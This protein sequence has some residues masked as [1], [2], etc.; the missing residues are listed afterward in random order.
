MGEVKVE[1]PTIGRSALGFIT[2]PADTRLYL[3]GYNS[4]EVD[5]G[6]VSWNDPDLQDGRVMRIATSNRL[7][8]D[9]ECVSLPFLVSGAVMFRP[10]SQDPMSATQGLRK[11]LVHK[12]PAIDRALFRE[13]KKFFKIRM[14]NHYRPIRP[15]EV[16]TYKEW[17]DGVNHPEWRKLEYDKAY[18]DVVNGRVDL[19]N[20]NKKKCFVKREFYPEPK[21]HRAIHSPTDHE[22][23]IEGP[24]A[25]AIENQV[26]SRPEYI[27]TV[28]RA[29]WPTYIRD[30]VAF[31]NLRWFSSDYSSFEASFVPEIQ[32]STE[33]KMAKFIL[34]I[35]LHLR[36]PRQ[37][38]SDAEVKIL[39][40]TLFYA[41]IR[42]RRSSGKMTTSVFNGV[43]NPAFVEFILRFL[44]GATEVYYVVE[45]DDGLYGHNGL[46]DPTPGDFLRLGLQIKLIPVDN[47]Y[48]ASFC[49]VVTHPDV[50]HTLCDPW[51][52]LLTCSWAG[53]D[54]VRAKPHVLRNLAQIK[55]LSYLAQYPGCP[56]VQSIALWILRVT[57]FDR[58]KLNDLLSWYLLERG[59]SWWDSRMVEDIR[60]SS[61]V[62]RAVQPGSR[63]V[64][65]R[66]FGVSIDI[67]LELENMFDSSV[68]TEVK[69]DESMVDP[70]YVKHW[71]GFV[72]EADRKSKDLNVP[73]ALP[74][75][76]YPENLRPWKRADF[77]TPDPKFRT[78]RPV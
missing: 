57:E 17:R 76:L 43:S 31:T 16:Q 5:L 21:F 45:G 24:F 78:Q 19:G 32:L 77:D 51:K 28:P 69:L 39:M 52:V 73:T 50:L 11:R 6:G 60:K 7:I 62:P 41:L 27:K 46:R 66:V 30:R 10:N 64:L 63:D 33:L 40:S 13:Y 65:A 71:A 22:K 15:D 74:E 23:V 56:V 55:G 49:G 58:Q 9:P 47:W 2:R 12:R 3:Y 34:S 14:H 35:M 38:L 68:T 53:H 1:R 67:Q 29:E 61:L 75:P 59:T 72:R 20:I 26:F 42:G 54:Y 37:M 8:R 18:E 36:G 4:D 25:K 44:C 48:E 70:R